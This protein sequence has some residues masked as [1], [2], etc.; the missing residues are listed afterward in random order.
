MWKLNSTISHIL[1]NISSDFLLF[2]EVKRS[3]R[4]N[5]CLI[6]G[7]LKVKTFPLLSWC[8]TLNSAACKHDPTQ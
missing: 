3:H 6:F 5:S 4:H 1:V 8:H 2:H 7:F